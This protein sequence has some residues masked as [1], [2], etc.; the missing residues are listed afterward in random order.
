MPT[1]NFIPVRALPYNYKILTSTREQWISSDK[2]YPPGDGIVCYTDG[3]L[4]D[5][6]AGSGV[7]F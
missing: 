1:D 2:I 6:L 4:C 7:F 3:S 5:G